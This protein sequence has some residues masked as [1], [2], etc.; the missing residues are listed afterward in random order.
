MNENNE[1]VS[2]PYTI[3]S[4][5]GGVG[6]I[7]LGFEQTKKFSSV[8]INEFDKNA[9]E[10]IAL[11]F[12]NVKLD[13]RDI[14]VVDTENDSN[15]DSHNLDTDLIVGGF[16][17]QAFS[18]AGYRKGFDDER[19]DLFFELYRIILKHKPRAIFIENVKNLV[20]HDHGNTFRVIREALTLAG[21]YIKWKV[22]N[23]KDYG[24]IPQNRE[25]IY[26]VGFSEKRAFEA[27]KFPEPVELT[28]KLSEVIDFEGLKED[29]YYYKKGKQPFYDKLEAEITSKEMIYQWR[30]QYVRSNKN[31]V[32]PTLTA[33]MGT[34]GHNVPLILSEFG[35]RKLTPR[36]TF[37]VQGF[38]KDFKLPDISNAQLYKQAG[39]SVVVPVIKRIAE[40]IAEALEVTS[41]KIPPV[42]IT[43]N[44][45]LFHVKMSGRT[46]GDSG[47]VEQFSTLSKLE[48][49]CNNNKI[50]VINE[51]EY[52]KKLKGNIASDFYITLN[53][54]DDYT[55]NSTMWFNLPKEQKERYKK[56]ITNF[57][58]LSEIFNQKKEFT[59]DIEVL[60]EK[61][62][63]IVNSK[64]QETV[65]QHSFNAIG[66][67]IKNTSYDAS[68][69]VDEK[70]KY[71]VGLKSFGYKSGK[72]KIAQFKSVSSSWDSIFSKIIQNSK[73]VEN[74][75][76]K[77][78]EINE[79]LYKELA[80]KIS[81]LRNERI[82][83]SKAT[84]K[85]F[86]YSNDDD[87]KA[88]YHYLLPSSTG[89]RP[90][91]FVGETPYYSIDIENIVIEKQSKGKFIPENFNF[92][93]GKHHYSYTKSDSQLH[94]YFDKTKL[95][96]WD[97]LYIV[98]PFEFF[99]NLEEKL[100]INEVGKD[101][102]DSLEDK[103]SVSW[104]ISNKNKEVEENSGYNGFYG[105]TKLDK[106][107]R[108]PR[109]QQIL[110][111]F[112]SQVNKV[113]MD[114]IISDLK[115]ILLRDWQTKSDRHDRNI[116]RDKLVEFVEDIGNSEL[117]LAVSNLVLRPVNEMYIPIPDA[118]K[119][120]TDNPDFFGPGIGTFE[121]GTSKLALPSEKRIFHLEFLQSGD[122]IDAYINQEAGKAI[123]SISNQGILGEWILHQVFRLRD[124]EPLTY[125]R[126]EELE[127][128]A[129]RL[130][131]FKDS[132]N[133][134][135]IEFIWIDENDI[136]KDAVGWIKKHAKIN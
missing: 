122:I 17:C 49:Y 109:I 77:C 115:T 67:D 105:A 4:F 101:S 62:A 90:Q 123:Q 30:R 32:V 68:I 85:G 22:L 8:F 13:R 20:T 60:Q 118:K 121:P 92:F 6:G 113:L 28:K 21:Y 91:I 93:D 27:F 11:N 18:V 34:G 132:V 111:R 31:G 83:S 41:R 14:H 24:N 88:V 128:N 5:F 25:R 80:I 66:E 69:I 106:K 72:Q 55:G 131:K 82:E 81:T 45:A 108:L 89:E 126:L 78:Q 56:F 2:T 54:F 38:P 99:S 135:G 104:M 71:L 57:A 35:I 116:I 52:I 129:I 130:T 75:R 19:G 42:K 37:N 119:F 79:E 64:F 51:D 117:L 10:T 124:R 95:E 134:I 33:N 43:K 9:Q 59:E 70:H 96:E 26:V 12:P 87:V 74:D 107:D 7:D 98:D 73:N 15:I 40:N 133:H 86:K 46:E 100:E 29:K 103:L 63:P 136:P 58:S 39:N 114:R 50:E 47:F 120:H 61:V 23:G 97:V 44:I 112:G 125:K 3:A 76:E 36:E 102:K 127:I 53:P 110:N 16:P 1:T 48:E 94:M 84:L 65:F